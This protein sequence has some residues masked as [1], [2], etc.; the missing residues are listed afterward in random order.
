MNKAFW[1]KS[2]LDDTV[3]TFGTR[4]NQ[5]IEALWKSF[6]KNWLI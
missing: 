5:A 3:T 4:P 6:D 1:E 2:Y